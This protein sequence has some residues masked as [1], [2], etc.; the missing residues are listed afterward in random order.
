LAN[1]PHARRPMP[2]TTTDTDMVAARLDTLLSAGICARCQLSITP[3]TADARAL[4]AEVIRLRG[5]LTQAR[6]ESAN[7]LAAMRAALSA[8]ADGEPNPLDYLI[9]ELP[10]HYDAPPTTGRG[11]V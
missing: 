9:W 10:E 8:A 1:T 7:R 11:R 2:Q 5:A 3:L 6:L 4:L